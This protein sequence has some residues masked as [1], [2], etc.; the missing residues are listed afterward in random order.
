MSNK[1]RTILLA[2]NKYN[3]AMDKI[4]SQLLDEIDKTKKK[5]QL[6][7][8]PNKN[9]N[10]NDIKNAIINA[11]DIIYIDYSRDKDL[12][13]Y[14]YGIYNPLTKSYVRDD[15]F[16]GDLIEFM[17]S[18][19]EPTP[20]ITTSS[21]KKAVDDAIMSSKDKIRIGNLPPSHIIKFKNCI[22]DL[23]LKQSYEFDEES[24][25]D[26]DFVTTVN[27]PLLQL[28]EV[29]QEMLSIVKRVFSLWSRDDH[30]VEKLIKQ[31]VYACIEGNGRNKYIIL[32]SEGGD[33][34]STFL[35]ILERFA[36]EK[37]TVNANLDEYNDDNVLNQID[38]ST[39][40]ITGD[41]LQSDF[42]M[43][44]KILSRFKILT[45]GGSLSV[46]VKYMP[47]KLIQS[48]SLKI[49]NT[50]TDIKFFE[51]NPAIKD[52]ILYLNWPH[53]N[54]RRN[55]ITDFNL[56]QLIG[57]N[58]PPNNDFM[59]ALL[60]YII[61]T[62]DYFEHFDVTNKMRNDLE[63]VINEN[64]TVLQHY[65]NLKDIGLL[66][67]SHIPSLIIYEHYKKWLK[68]VNP[69]AKPMHQRGYTKKIHQY[70]KDDGYIDQDTMI[71]R[72]LEKDQFNIYLFDD[73][74]VDD[75]VRSKIFI[76]P[77]LDIESRVEEIEDDIIELDKDQIKDKYDESLIR[78]YLNYV[79]DKNPAD[80]LIL[81]APYQTNEINDL[82]I[83]TIIEKLIDYY[84]E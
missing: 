6:N 14:T 13:N 50:N 71:L 47:N 73:I 49:Q 58:G 72:K 76:N 41:D 61:H 51:N 32:K 83:D 77:D 82:N 68:I 57:K 84:Q 80:Y 38:P 30:D 67:Y 65:L 55:P 81:I 18:H 75:S 22:Y 19:I 5:N 27:Y 15:L 23:K 46:G 1:E 3:N 60:S 9:I 52:R 56:D 35:T 70:F 20:T 36:Q 25:E 10:S 37:L 34:K 79:K 26:Y 62:T 48:N 12:S 78:S 24:I 59:I 53:Y 63:E 7:G 42:K 28:D 64:D 31:F 66:Q 54:F 16:L 74:Q 45:S 69:S 4:H 2:N 43:N 33:G 8:T 17:I 40:L 39:K 44:N 21:I 11:C 29:N